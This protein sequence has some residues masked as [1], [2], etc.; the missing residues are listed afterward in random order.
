MTNNNYHEKKRASDIYFTNKSGLVC[1]GPAIIDGIY[2]S[3]DGVNAD[4]DIYDGPNDN[5]PRK[6]HFEALAGTSFGAQTHK[7][8]VMQ[9]GIYLVVSATTTY[10]TILW[11][12]LDA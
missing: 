4:C 9:A 1:I 2:I 3:G 7:G 8:A 6:F 12:P 5:A 10:V 11:R